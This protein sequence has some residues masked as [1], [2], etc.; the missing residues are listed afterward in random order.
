MPGIVF[1]LWYFSTKATDRTL[2]IYRED[3]LAAQA[4]HSKEIAEIRQMYEN[5]VK[6]VQDYGMLASDLRS[7][8]TLNTQCWQRALDDINRNQFCP[9]VRLRKEAPGKVDE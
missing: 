5:N 3:F 4:K 9:Y 8:V 6:L 2:L 7:V 1:I